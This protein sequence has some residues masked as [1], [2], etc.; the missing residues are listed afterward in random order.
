VPHR[1]IWSGPQ[2]SPGTL[3]IVH[4]GRVKDHRPAEAPA[5]FRGLFT[6]GVK[7]PRP[8]VGCDARGDPDLGVGDTT[9]AC[10]SQRL[11][12]RQP[13]DL[14]VRVPH[15]QR[16]PPPPRCPAV[17]FRQ[18]NESTRATSRVR[19]PDAGSYAPFHN[20]PQV[21]ISNCAPARI[22]VVV[23]R[24]GGCRRGTGPLRA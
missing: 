16:P 8:A 21:G 3:P 13:V 1:V 19:P 23:P 14:T 10:F 22:L 4:A 11:P 18:P 24:A 6:Y 9:S 5:C 15:P 2:G 12:C 7:R 17:M 20:S